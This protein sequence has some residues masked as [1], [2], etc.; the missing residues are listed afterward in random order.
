M[1]RIF[2]FFAILRTG[3]SQPSRRVAKMENGRAT[4]RSRKVFQHRGHSP[5]KYATQDAIRVAAMD[6]KSPR[7][8]RP[9]WPE[10]NVTSR[11]SDIAHA[12]GH[13]AS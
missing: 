4:R 3:Y 9:L 7:D 11:A 10:S 8:V 6:Q 1:I 5:M 2:T 12:F 13:F